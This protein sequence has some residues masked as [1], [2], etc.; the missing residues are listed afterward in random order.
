VNRTDE[1]L[2]HL[3]SIGVK[4]WTEDNQIRYKAPKGVLTPALITHMKEQKEE[5][6]AFLHDAN[7]ASNTHLPP[8][9]PTSRGST[10]PLSFAQERLWFLYQLEGQTA[11]Y[12][13]PETLLLTGT[14]HVTALERSINNLIR[15]HEALR[16][17]IGIK[18]G[19]TVQVIAPE[20]TIPLPVVDLQMLPKAERLPEA[21]RLA[22]DEA[23]LPFDAM[24]GPLLRVSLLRLENQE[25]VL[26][27]TMHHIVSDGWSKGILTREMAVLYEA[28]SQGKP[29]P[30]SELSIQYADYASWQRQWMAGE[31]LETQ[32]DFWKRRLNE[33]PPLLELPADRSRPAIRSSHGGVLRFEIDHNL[34]KQLNQLSKDADVTI[35]MTL[36]SVFTTL[37]YRYCDKEDI[38]IGTNTANR[39]RAEIESVIGFFVNTLVLRI[40]LTGNPS[41]LE[42]LR[43]VRQVA[44]EAYSHQDIPF[45]KLVEALQ[46]ERS[47]SH[48]PLVQVMFLLQNAPMGSLELPGLV[49]TPL[50]TERFTSKFDLTV[51]MEERADG[52]RG[53]IEYSTDLFDEA[54][55]IRMIDHF[56]AL[57]GA[58]VA[59]PGERISLFSFLTEA[60][61]KQLLVEWNNTCTQNIQNRCIHELF[62]D[63]VERLP[64]A[65]AV[66][67]P[68]AGTDQMGERHITYWELFVRANQLARYL[69][70]LNVGP[71]VKVGICVDRSIEMIVGLLGILKAGG[72][73]VPIDPAFPT[74]RIAV[75]L[76][77]AEVSVVLTQ[78]KSQ[79][80][81]SEIRNQK[82]G[83]KSTVL[84]CLDTDWGRIS[85]EKKEKPSS[86][87]KP[88]N[89]A[90]V[91]YTSGSTGSP[92]GVMIEHRSVV[93]LVSAL[94]ETVY[95]D[96]T[97]PL[98]VGLLAS[99]VFDASVQQIFACLLHGH[100][101]YLV[102]EETRRDGK[103]LNQ[104]FH[105]YAIDIADC[106]PSLLSIMVKAGEPGIA[107][108]ALKQ[109]IVGGEALPTSLVRE[110]YQQERTK[111]I[112]LA[113]V[114]GPTECCVDVTAY[115]IDS[116]YK[117]TQTVVPIGRPLTN[118]R[119]Y[120]IDQQEN[121]TPVG[122]P[123][124]ICVAGAGVGRGYLNDPGLTALKFAS[125]SSLKE[126]RLYRT[127][128]IGHW[129]NDGKIAFI[130]RNDDQ[131]KIRGYRI[132]PGEIE[133][134]LCTH[135]LVSEALVLAKETS[136][137]YKELIAYLVFE[138]T[139][140]VSELRNYLE[141]K[142]PEYMIPSYFIALE[143]FPHNKS[144]KIDRNALPLPD[145]GDTIDQGTQYVRPGD[146]REEKL[147]QVWS[148]VLGNERIG[149]R[150]NFFALGG[151]S[152]K[153]L[154][155]VARLREEGIKL[156][157][158]DLFLYPNV[159]ELAQRLVG[160]EPGSTNEENITGE[161]PLTAIQQWFFQEYKGAT[162]HYNQA[163]L[164][165][166]REKLD[167][168]ILRSV[169]LK[170]QEHH[171]AL[172][173]RYQM[174]KGNWIQQNGNTDYPMGFE[175]VNF[176]DTEDPNTALYKHSETVQRSIDLEQGPMIK[177]ILYRL[178]E[179]D[180]LFLMVHHLVI[181]GVSWRIILED[182]QT[183]Y[184]QI[185]N[186]E[187]I[188]LPP[189]T[190]SFK[191]WAEKLQ[192]Y[193]NTEV[194]DEKGYWQER[195][196][197]CISSLPV[198]FT[199]KEDVYQNSD[200]C[201][202]KL[203]VE[204]TKFLLTEVHHAYNTE[205]NDIL[206]TALGR[207]M[208][209]WT[210]NAE[211]AIM[212]EGHGREA[213][214]EN[215]DISRTVGWFTSMFPIL[216]DLSASDDLGRQ[217]KIVKENLRSIP[218][219]GI[220]YGILKFITAQRHKTDLAL[221]LQPQISFNYLGQFGEEFESTLFTRAHEKIAPSID[222][223]AQ[224]P[225]EL[226][227]VGIIIDDCFEMCVGY[228]KKG[229]MKET[230]HRFLSYYQEELVAII[231]H[232]REKIE[233]ELTPSDI[234]YKGFNI[235]ELE[236]FLN[237]L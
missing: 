148:K 42:L 142:L 228:N 162:N 106:T 128:D 65:V 225:F 159:E 188:S 29:S 202:F 207:A 172:R 195:E 161:V 94:F 171:D 157:I 108:S 66:V 96:Y 198:D 219:K 155:V 141:K 126:T 196:T 15:R 183:A 40:D 222:P 113:N 84:V 237:K 58:V 135:P 31:M 233:P 25:H 213:L 221:T 32:L 43:R 169:L 163:F 133:S 24:K 53:E 86:D 114:Y 77:D 190:D 139:L 154:Q 21:L 122:I 215:S 153:A 91:I 234:D 109:L 61:R 189:R 223:M 180:R 79:S 205:I 127:G 227:L 101:L 57:L 136:G 76:E 69:Q 33:A 118:T 124:E 48:N 35:F 220:G 177:G 129:T 98:R 156:E 138:E 62:D 170:I 110:F 211:T 165:S 56:M 176:Q 80:V 166:A 137:D 173:M 3:R 22:V 164:L 167:E 204:E 51:L 1:F 212:L 13:V 85:Q 236:N 36:L 30:L 200:V 229:F 8:I 95:A 145:E 231:N 74:E 121:P 201:S 4:L 11:T 216:I 100:S 92:R 182:L 10:I 81:F 23:N 89:L 14:I 226:E 123:G 209:H 149:A 38:I 2:S 16:T 184:R 39:T 187:E 208:Y 192:A 140:T 125:H 105:E 151:D 158:R 218:R 147:V 71:E 75:M 63:Q 130:G 93:N 46:P 37:L 87:V 230:I 64:D 199:V 20:L 7:R 44:L 104:F 52:L 28:F 232:M 194:L 19:K 214:F 185:R 88:E 50:E 112:R 34:T 102:D 54:T 5:I 146:E 193:S 178:P 47:L 83:G 60:E 97:G 67:L 120:I 132:E 186:G 18:E 210:G 99:M 174:Y 26:F 78:K 49:I 116:S 72:A 197:F 70:S 59:D 27:L 107:G 115:T 152:I 134:H 131:V 181:D 175:C 217:I 191:C 90:Y 103:Q 144:G 17:T 55:I 150:G 235:E 160:I 179:G 6:L 224:R 68:F 119:V 168:K 111:S 206:I 41:F 143:S 45:E 12:N 203:S 82:P 9:R 73:Y 117:S